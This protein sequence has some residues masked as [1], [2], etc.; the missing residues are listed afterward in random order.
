MPGAVLVQ[1]RRSVERVA[2]LVPNRR[3]DYTS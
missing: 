1:D 3:E 2:L